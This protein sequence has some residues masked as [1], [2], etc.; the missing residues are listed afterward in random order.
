MLAKSEY[1]AV[2]RTRVADR[3][4]VLCEDSVRVSVTDAGPGFELDRRTTVS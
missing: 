2:W 1:P 3:S 4:L